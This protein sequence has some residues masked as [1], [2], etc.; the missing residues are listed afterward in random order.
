MPRPNAR[1]V[2]VVDDE[3]DIREVARVSLEAIGGYEVRTAGGGEEGLLVARSGWPEAILL[4]VMMPEMTGYQVVAALRA[5]AAT[6]EI[7]VVLLSATPALAARRALE[8][9]GVTHRITKPFDPLELP[10][11][12]AEELGWEGKDT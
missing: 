10:R 3:T 6:R 1:R 7:P 9:L 11:L 2:L 8:E 4:D 12:L 5:D